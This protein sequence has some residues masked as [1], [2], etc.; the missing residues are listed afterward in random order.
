MV[1]SLRIKLKE[2]KGFTLIELLAVIVIL[3]IIA[4]IAIPAIGNVINNSKASAIKTDAQH[5]LNAT[6]LYVAEKGMPAP[7]T[8]SKADLTDYIDDVTTFDDFTITFSGTKP[9]ISGTGT[10]GGKSITF[11][12]ATI[13]GID[14]AGN[15]FSEIKD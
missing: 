10:K 7:A 8:L 13:S 4:A 9:Q 5:I 2:Q 6:K 1:E 12:K 14:K 15:D 11:T 3:G